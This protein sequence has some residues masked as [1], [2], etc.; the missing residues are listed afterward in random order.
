MIVISFCATILIVSYAFSNTRFYLELS[1]NLARQMCFMNSFLS[2]L[3]TG[4]IILAS[5]RDHLGR[6]DFKSNRPIRTHSA[7][8]NYLE[9]FNRTFNETILKE[10]NGKSV[11]SHTKCNQLIL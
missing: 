7:A 1:W 8:E 4:R 5:S 3:Y 9:L 2:F 11:I 6:L 10:N